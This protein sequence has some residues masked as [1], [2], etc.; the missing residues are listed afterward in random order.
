MNHLFVSK[1]TYR[2]NHYTNQHWHLVTM[3]L[4]ADLNQND[5]VQ[6]ANA[7]QF[8]SIH[9]KRHWKSFKKFE[10]HKILWNSIEI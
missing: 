7:V 8:G 3:K 10:F 1:L 2:L 5:A 4:S 6:P 9:I